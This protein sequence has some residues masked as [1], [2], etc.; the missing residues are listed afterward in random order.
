VK[1]KVRIFRA[2]H[3]LTQEELATRLGVSRHTII[4]IENERFDPSLGLAY[5]IAGLFGV[6]I[7]DIF[8]SERKNPV[9]PTI[10]P[11]RAAPAGPAFRGRSGRS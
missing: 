4:A 1:N 7:E 11:E 9:Y 3:R 8:I 5:N 6:T 10:V 2:V